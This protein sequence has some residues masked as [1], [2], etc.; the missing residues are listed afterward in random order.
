MRRSFNLHLA[1]IAASFGH[2]ANAEAQSRIA[3]NRHNLLGCKSLSGYPDTLLPSSETNVPP[4][5]SIGV[6]SLARVVVAFAVHTGMRRGE[7][8]NLKW[9]DVDLE[10]G[11]IFVRN[12]KNCR[13][14]HRWR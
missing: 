8:L 5:Q 10:Q 11:M 2:A 13:V 6:R 4:D 14:M 9:Q 7:I 1:P 3:Q 12:T